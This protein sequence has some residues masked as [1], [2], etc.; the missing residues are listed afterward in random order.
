MCLQKQA[1]N[2]LFAHFAH[3]IQICHQFHS[4]RYF[5]TADITNHIIINCCTWVC[6]SMSAPEPRLC[7][8]CDIYMKQSC[9]WCCK[10]CF[11]DKCFT[12]ERNLIRS[13]VKM[14]NG[15][16]RS[17]IDCQQSWMEM[18]IKKKSIISLASSK[19][20]CLLFLG[21]WEMRRLLTD[22]Q[23]HIVPREKRWKHGWLSQSHQGNNESVFLE[24][25]LHWK[26]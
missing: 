8:C 12:A 14:K 25:V 20:S 10:L 3:N 23:V 7:A 11:S 9:H 5:S 13:I 21:K 16:S 2:V 1:Q 24:M 17:L 4:S 15:G 22:T 18:C 26:K 19:N 6:C